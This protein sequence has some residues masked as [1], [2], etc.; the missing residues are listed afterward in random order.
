MLGFLR[1]RMFLTAFTY[2][3][4]YW[5]WQKGTLITMFDVSYGR[6]LIVNLYKRW[7]NKHIMFFI[8]HNLRLFIFLQWS[9]GGIPPNRGW[10]RLRLLRLRL[11]P[12]LLVRLLRHF[13][14]WS[15]LVTISNWI[16]SIFIV[17]VHKFYS[18]DH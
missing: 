1:V 6:A 2:L 10:G 13:L 17:V 14:A 7:S 5:A 4:K 18:I 15:V 16:C 3:W 8:W 11:L 12:L 9:C